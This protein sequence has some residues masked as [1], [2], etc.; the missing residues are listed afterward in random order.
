[1]LSS[2]TTDRLLKFQ[3]R[4]PDVIP[5]FVANCYHTLICWHIREAHQTHW[6]YEFI[7]LRFG[8]NRR[9]RSCHE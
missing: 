4:Q 7:D 2:R 8:E 5:S 3:I 6:S 9:R 1:M